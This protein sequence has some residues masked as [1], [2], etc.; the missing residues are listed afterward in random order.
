MKVG[1]LLPTMQFILA[2]LLAYQAIIVNAGVSMNNPFFCYA[3]DTIRSMTH[4]ASTITSYEAHRRFN[5]ATVDPYVSS[6]VST[7]MLTD[8]E[9]FVF[10]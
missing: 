6:K 7:H 1:L 3:T 8:I 10:I 9:N 4:M 2:F 5:F